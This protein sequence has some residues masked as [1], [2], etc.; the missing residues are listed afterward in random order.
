MND[1]HHIPPYWPLKL[2]RRLL[3]NSYLEEIEGDLEERFND[4]VEVYDFGKARRLYIQDALKVLRPVLLRRLG[5]EYKLNQYDMFKHHLKIAFRSFRKEKAFTTINLLGLSLGICCTLLISLWVI[6]EYNFDRFHDKGDRIYQV[7][8][9][10]NFENGINTAFGTAYPIGDALEDNIPEVVA[11]TRVATLGNVAIEINGKQA[12]VQFRG[13]DASFFDIFSFPLKVG[14]PSTCLTKKESIVISKQLADSFF[15]NKSAV[16]EA[17]TVLVEGDTELT[18]YVSAVMEDFPENSSMQFDCMILLDNFLPFNPTHDS[19]GNS[20]LTTYVLLDKQAESIEVNEKIRHIPKEVAG[21]EWFTLLL[22]P[23][24]DKYLRSEFQDGEVVGGRIDNVILFSIIATFSLL[25]ACF[26]FINLTTARSAKRSKEIGIKKVL[27]AGKTTLL[28]QFTLESVL[29]TFG[30]IFVAILLTYLLLPWFNELTSK[31]LSVD[32]LNPFFYLTLGLITLGTIVLS[33]LY[34]AF[35][36]SSFQPINALK[37]KINKKLGTYQVG[38]VL[39]VIQFSLS[40]MLIAGSLIV[41]QQLSYIHSQDLGINK[42]QVIYNPMDFNTLVNRKGFVQELSNHSAIMEVSAASG[43]FINWLGSSSDPF[44]EGKA[45]DAGQLWFAILNV[46]FGML[47][48][49]DIEVVSGRSFS[50]AYGTD[51][52]N[53]IINEKAAEI[54]GLDD[55]LNK[56]MGF[57]GDEGGKI[58]GVVKNFHFLSLHSP[59][60]PMIIRCRPNQ[61]DLVYVKT[62]PGKTE[63]AL[64]HMATAHE[65]FSTLPFNYYFLDETISNSYQQEHRIQQLAGSFSGLAILISCLGLLGLASYSAQQRIKE[66]AIRKVFG[67]RL[68]NLIFILF[69]SYFRLI[70]IGIIISIPLVYSWGSS[71]LNNFAFSIS[72]SWWVYLL[73]VI[74]ILGIAFLTISKISI[75]VAH[76]NPSDS[77][78]NE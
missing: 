68:S 22:H 27:G 19:W 14:E 18:F 2:L 63:E 47:E 13:T 32:L 1:L 67:A 17:V 55:P 15:P 43:D 64:L 4:N 38:K 11:Q 10:Q 76:N 62:A 5:G 78:R 49:M 6:D 37:G 36:L 48:L 46:D 28:N 54:M 59:I 50:K 71:W 21:V 57:W 40:T 45:P 41:Y 60:D 74:I 58:V 16:G 30:G 12:E 52:L 72:I 26:N 65:K 39:M 20:W 75:R 70:I 8:R 66:I 9:N 44:W 77:L 51:T 24:E 61:T 33:G 3:N 73:P 42:E 23:F 34:P 29:L 53:Y 7:I 69:H 35:F 31:G 56:S 25:I